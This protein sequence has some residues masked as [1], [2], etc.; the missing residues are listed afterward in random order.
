MEA[1]GEAVRLVTHPLQQEQC[2]TP[3][4]QR[5]RFG[6]AGQVDLL[7]PLGQ[8]RHRDLVAQAELV[9]H[10]HGHTELALATVDEQELRRVGEL[11]RPAPG[12]IGR[13]RL[14]DGIGVDER[15]GVDE[16]GVALGEVG[17]QASPEHLFHRR[18][19]VVAVDVLHLEAAVLALVGQAVGEHHHRTDV[20]GALQVGHVVALDAQRSLGQP[21]RVLQLGERPAAAV[22][23]G[24]P[25]QPVARELLLG[26]AR[27]R[28]VQVAFVAA[29]RHPDLDPRAAFVREPLL[30]HRTVLRVDRDEHLLRHTEGRLVAVQGLQDAVDQAP[31][32]EVLHL[33]EHEALAPDDATLADVE[34][35]DGGLELVVGETDDVD[36]LAALG[37]HLLLLDRPLHGGE[38]VAIA[39]RLLV[40]QFRRG[41]LH[42]PLQAGDDLVGVAIEELAELV[43]EGVVARLVD[44]ADARARALLDVEQQ[45]RSAEPVV[46][47]VLAG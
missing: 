38:A 28:L 26:V 8:R 25:A 32:R 44:L 37:H 30:V 34:D 47:V 40:L 2:F 18:V 42:L 43:D 4:R 11:L 21:E 24:C 13:R 22:V 23:I 33:V 29:L 10:L 31:R 45:A 41:V 7:E 17:R 6:V 16:R 1:V 46:L 9:E 3:P 15:V 14:H 20:V 12:R 39:G 5:N 27:H 35:L 19:V 36:V